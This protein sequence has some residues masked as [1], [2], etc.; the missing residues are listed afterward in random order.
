M[1]D[2]L[3]IAGRWVSKQVLARVSFCAAETPPL[4]P[5]AVNDFCRPAHCCNRRGELSVSPP[6]LVLK[7]LDQKHNDLII[8]L[9]WHGESTF[10][11]GT[12]SYCALYLSIYIDTLSESEFWEKNMLTAFIY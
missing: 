10:K 8:I 5:T 7:R 3:R 1:L 4:R 9:T 6:I 12:L 2:A 11:H